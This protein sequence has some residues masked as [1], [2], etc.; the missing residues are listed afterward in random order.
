[1]RIVQPR[2]LRLLAQTQRALRRI[3]DARDGLLIFGA[4]LY[5]AGYIAWSLYAWVNHLGPVA[6][7][8][9]QYFIAGIPVVAVF[10]TCWWVG[11]ATVHFHRNVWPR[12]YYA[13]SVRIQWI[14]L[15]LVIPA[16]LTAYALYMYLFGPFGRPSGAPAILDLVVA[17]AGVLVMLLVRRPSN[18]KPS[19]GG[20]FFDRVTTRQ[21]IITI[22]IVV[23]VF[24]LFGAA[25]YLQ[26]LYPKIPQVIGGAA[27]RRA[28]IDLNV[29]RIHQRPLNCYWI[30]HLK[31][32]SASLL[33]GRCWCT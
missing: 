12:W 4:L 22:Y 10:L 28:V 8:D 7:L 30:G 19:P 16:L 24:A 27:P 3:G 33:A 31:Q 17:I 6:G 23:G 21:G 14:L 5:G 9:A 11:N 1:M 32:V 20:L 18:A 2:S 26:L 13:K 25:V 15:V 29:E